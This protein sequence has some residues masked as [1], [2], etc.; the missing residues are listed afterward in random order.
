MMPNTAATLSWESIVQRGRVPLLIV[1]HGQTAWNAEHRFLGRSDIP[2]NDVGWMQVKEVG[3]FLSE[4]PLSAAYS[5]PLSR[6]TQTAGAILARRSL[7]LSQD[8]R[9][10]ELDQGHLEGKTAQALVSEHAEFFA[11]WKIDPA[12]C[13][14]PG[15][16]SFQECQARGMAALT[17]LAEQAQPGPPVLVVTHNMLIRSV[18]CAIRGLPLSQFRNIDQE[19]A[20]VNLL[21]Y[22][23]G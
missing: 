17:E 10:A 13:R 9:L 21:S 12:S 14:V 18:V 11:A 2:L 7:P 16:E 5:S 6:A 1:R 4:I 8:P 15:G 22:G 3:E 19:N 20:A 23:D